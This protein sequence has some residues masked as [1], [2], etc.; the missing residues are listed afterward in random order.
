MGVSTHDHGTR[1][2]YRAGCRCDACRQWKSDDNAK[3]RT[4]KTP[5][6]PERSPDEPP[7]ETPAADSPQSPHRP[8]AMEKAVAVDLESIEAATPE[9]GLLFNTLRAA[10]VA[11]AREIDSF[12]STSKAPL[13]KQ[14]LEVM[15]KLARKDSDDD[16]LAFLSGLA[17]EFATT[18]GGDDTES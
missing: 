10:A 8:G 12:G 1:G 11:L 3:Y 5:K 4:P 18:S 15:S 2:R 16:P 14:L 6:T 7:P 9:P 13:V 17:D